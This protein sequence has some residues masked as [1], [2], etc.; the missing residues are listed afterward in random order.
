MKIITSLAVALAL[1]PL[2]A[3]NNGPQEQPADNMDASTDL[4]TDNLE[5]AAQEAANEASQDSLN[6]ARSAAADAKRTAADAN[7]ANEAATGAR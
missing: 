7:N 4:A 2:A 5:Q 1:G 3:C 6:Q